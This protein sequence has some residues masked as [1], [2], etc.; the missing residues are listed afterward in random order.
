MFRAGMEAGNHA[1]APGRRHPLRTW[2]L[3]LAYRDR[4]ALG[5]VDPR[6][7]SLGRSIHATG[8]L[9]VET[10]GVRHEES[11]AVDLTRG[12]SA[13]RRAG[14][15]DPDV[16]YDRAAVAATQ[17]IRLLPT[18]RLRAGWRAF[19]GAAWRRAPNEALFDAAEGPRLDAVRDFYLNDR[20]P[21][22]ASGHALFEG[23]A[24]VRGYADRAALGKRAWGAGLSLTHS[25]V[26]LSGLLFA[27]AGRVEAAGFGES[28]P[29]PAG[30]LVGRTLFDAGVTFQLGP[31][32]LTL[33][34]W[35]SRP[36]PGERPW[37]LRWR[38]SLLR[39]WRPE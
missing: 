27:D 38:A 24:G 11:L 17:T 39:G 18:G 31:L 15:S 30:P 32:R 35:L 29:A 37:K 5:P 20:G 21:V 1:T 36:A 34:V 33:P 2:T 19:A 25:S 3:G 8:S 22:R 26:P 16:Q 4:Y 10:I 23:G 14:D 28:P 7:W 13:F 12:A 6:Y 9:R